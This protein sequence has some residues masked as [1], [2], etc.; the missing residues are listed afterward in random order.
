MIRAEVLQEVRLMKSEDVYSRRTAGKL[1]QEQAAGI[2]GVSV[3][4]VRR[5]EDRHEAEGADGLYDRRLGKLANTRVPTE[6]L[7]LFDTRYRD[8]TPKHFH[9]KPIAHHG[10]TWSYNWLRLSLQS[11]GRVQPAS[12]RGAH[13]RKQPRRPMVGMMLRQDG[14]THAWVP[15]QWWDLIVTMNDADNRIYPALFVAVEGTMSS[16]RGMTEVI[17]AHGLFYS[18][19]VNRGSHYWHTP[20]AGSKGDKSNLAQVGRALQQLGIE[21]IPAW[22]PQARGARSGCSLPCRTD[23]HR[24]RGRTPSPPSCSCRSSERSM[25]V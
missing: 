20:E 11:H 9:E 18:L 2:L 1:T 25:L 10:F 24:N 12:R 16:F 6:M 21:L 5:W 17:E 22:S 3:R 23:C 7:D 4:T 13:R 15:E 8:Y 19:H 14:S